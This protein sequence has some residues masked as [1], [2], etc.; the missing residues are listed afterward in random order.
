MSHPMEDIYYRQ[1]DLAEVS[2]M[3]NFEM[4]DS[5][6]DDVFPPL[7]SVFDPDVE[8]EL[9]MILTPTSSFTNEDP[10]PSFSAPTAPTT[11]ETPAMLQIQITLPPRAGKWIL[12]RRQS[13]GSDLQLRFTE[14]RKWMAYSLVGLWAGV[15]LL[16]NGALAFSLV[17]GFKAFCSC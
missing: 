4:D 11:E 13:A 5:E 2:E 8:S 3:D 17:R 6:I 16:M 15:S 12:W 9:D 10:A 1:W 14:D 7:W